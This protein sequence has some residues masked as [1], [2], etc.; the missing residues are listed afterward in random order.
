MALSRLHRN[1]IRKVNSKDYPKEV[2]EVWSGKTNVGKFRR[3]VTS[4]YLYLAEIKGKIVGFFSMSKDD[5]Q[6]WMVY[7]HKDYIGK[8]VGTKLMDKMESI[9]RKRRLT[10]LKC[11]SSLTAKEFYLKRGFQLKGPAKHE[12]EWKGK[13]VN[14]DVWEMEKKL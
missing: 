6:D 11:A 2:I 9:A 8:G 7:I 1:T 4:S 12:M 13:V 10:V 14:V 5:C 3:R